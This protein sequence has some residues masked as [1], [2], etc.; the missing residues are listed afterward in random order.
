MY[1]SL[2]KAAKLTG[3][4]KSVL[5]N[6]IKK[7]RI[8]AV[9]ND[10]GHWDIETSELFR[11]YPAHNQELPKNGSSTTSKNDL[12]PAKEPLEHR[13]LEQKIEFKD[14]KILMLEQQLEEAKEREQE[15]RNILNQNTK[16]LT[17]YSDKEKQQLEQLEPEPVKRKWSWFKS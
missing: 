13:L 12:V 11:V 6:A 1:I 4:S 15:L 14:E 7:G 2:S 16:L 9:Q 10:K 3:K 8:S 17:H 5:S